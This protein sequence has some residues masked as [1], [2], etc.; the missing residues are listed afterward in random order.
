M[1]YHVLLL[2]LLL[3]MMIMILSEEEARVDSKIVH[4]HTRKQ[5][6]DQKE[7]HERDQRA[8]LVAA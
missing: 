7:N 4:F 8:S 5:V 6:V 3:Q 1:I 2:L